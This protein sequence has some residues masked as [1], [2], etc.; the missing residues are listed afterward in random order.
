MDGSDSLHHVEVIVIIDGDT[1]V[2]ELTSHNL[3][4]L[5][6]VPRRSVL[7]GRVTIT[8]NQGGVVAWGLHT[9]ETFLLH[10]IEERLEDLLGVSG[11]NLFGCGSVL[12]DDG[13][14]EVAHRFGDLLMSNIL[15]DFG[16]QVTF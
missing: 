13:L 9:V 5:L 11:V 1:L 6:F 2:L 7:T 10:G 16:S 3:L 12:V 15:G 8:V 14:D 4:T